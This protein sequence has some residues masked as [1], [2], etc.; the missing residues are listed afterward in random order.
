MK[1][2]CQKCGRYIKIQLHIFT[3][4]EIKE[5]NA[6]HE[7]YEA[8]CKKCGKLNSWEVETI[9]CKKKK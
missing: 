5:N 1:H 6:P 2:K 7:C 9:V 3:D 8:I 4:K